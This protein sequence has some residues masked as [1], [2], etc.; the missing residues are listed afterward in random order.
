MTFSAAPW[1][2]LYQTRHHRTLLG[3]THRPVILAL[4]LA[5]ATTLPAAAA[6]TATPTA[7]SFSLHE[8]ISIELVFAYVGNGGRIDGYTITADPP[9]QNPPMGLYQSAEAGFMFPIPGSK[10]PGRGIRH[11]LLLNKWV[12]LDRP[13]RYN[14]TIDALVRDRTG[15]NRVVTTVPIT[16]VERDEARLQ[17]VCLQWAERA[18]AK[19]PKTEGL[20]DE[21]YAQQILMYLQEESLIPCLLHSAS[22]ANLAPAIAF[23]EMDSVA[24]VRAL[25]ELIRSPVAELARDAR[26][27]LEQ[28]RERT[29]KDVVRKA[30]VVALAAPLR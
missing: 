10:V 18:N 19:S 21:I 15:V 16:L 24:A 28:L 12:T 5:W 20:Q 6:L 22:K 4:G 9:G 26:A 2:F 30:A 17:R 7:D 13:G 14:V 11:M 27:R 23:R 8:P 29:K 1:Q 3:W 25:Q